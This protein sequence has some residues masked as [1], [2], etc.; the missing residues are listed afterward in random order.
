MAGFLPPPEPISPLRSSFAFSNDLSSPTGESSA[1]TPS[2][3]T[4][5][6]LS[7]GISLSSE[8]GT[9]PPLESPVQPLAPNHNSLSD[10]EL[11]YANDWGLPQIKEWLESMNCGMYYWAFEG[12]FLSQLRFPSLLL[13]RYYRTRHLWRYSS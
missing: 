3:R 6:N 13:T 2:T 5:G 12:T 7:P 8:H 1:F 4:S 11:T 10:I 9:S